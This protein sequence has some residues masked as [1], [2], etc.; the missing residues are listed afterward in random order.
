M[1]Y[2]NGNINDIISEDFLE[3]A[4]HVM[5]ERSIPD[6]RDGLK[7]GARKILFIQYKDKNV[8]TKNFIKGGAAV[9]EVLKKGYLHGDAS[10]YGTL[11]RLGKRF[12]CPYVLEELQGNGGNQVSPDN[13]ASMR[14]LELRQSELA[15][16][17][18][19]GI[20]KNAIN[21]WYWNYANTL[22][23]PRVLPTIGFYPIVNGLSGM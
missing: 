9:G 20:E 18:F 7:D 5:Q 13:H 21:E 16:Y 8:H 23:L 15:S 14:Y 4:G 2:I 6:A 3:Y 12:A 22:E 11:V 17:L 19:K 1:P 10:A